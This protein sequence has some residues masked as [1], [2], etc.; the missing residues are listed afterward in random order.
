MNKQPTKTALL[1]FFKE[2]SILSPVV[3]KSTAEPEN[4]NN[5]TLANKSTPSNRAFFVRGLRTPKENNR[6]K[7][8]LVAFLSMVGRN[9]Q[10][11]IVGC[12]PVGAVF[13]PVTLYRQ[14][15]KL[16]VDV[17][18]LQLGFSAML[19]KFLTGSRLKITIR[20]N[21]EQEARQRLQLSDSAICIAR[22]SNAFLAQKQAKLTACKGVSYA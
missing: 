22:Y 20:A 15:W 4:S 3:A 17:Q 12:S 8:E 9:G 7:I 21:S 2:C 19:F 5:Q 13:H 16:A 14:A 18:N 10:R 6:L 11:L 1:R